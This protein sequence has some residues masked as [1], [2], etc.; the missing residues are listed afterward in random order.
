MTWKKE[1]LKKGTRLGVRERAGLSSVIAVFVPCTV[2][3]GYA[4]LLAVLGQSFYKFGHMLFQTGHP[5]APSAC[6]EKRRTPRLRKS[7]R[8]LI[9]KFSAM[10]Q[11]MCY[12]ISYVCRYLSITKSV[13]QCL[14]QSLVQCIV[15]FG[16]CVVALNLF[17]KYVGSTFITF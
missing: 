6:I 8:K 2:I 1:N 10:Y 5:T 15:Q 13:M 12:T 3:Q 17:E 11:T 7:L 14:K 4:F 16:M 9:A